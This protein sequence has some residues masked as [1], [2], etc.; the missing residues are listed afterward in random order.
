MHYIGHG[1][2]DSRTEGGILVL[3]NANGDSHEVTGEELGS[4]LQD[5]RSMRL[6]VL[7]A[8]EGARGSHVDPFC[9][10]AS[11]LVECGISAVVGMQFE[12]TDEAAI[13]FGGRL[14]SALAQGFPID[15]ALAQSRK[16]IFAAGHDIEFGT[17]VLFLRAAD[18][19]LFDPEPPAHPPV[20]PP[21]VPEPQVPVETLTPGT[22][23]AQATGD[24]AEVEASKPDRDALALVGAET[25]A[26]S[27]VTTDGRLSRGGS[28]GGRPRARPD[29]CRRRRH[30]G[31]RA[32]RPSEFARRRT[33]S[34]SGFA[35]VDAR[36]GGLRPCRGC[37][38]LARLGVGV[39]SRAGRFGRGRTGSA[40]AGPVARDTGSSPAGLRSRGR[41][42]SR[43]GLGRGR[44]AREASSPYRGVGVSTGSPRTLGPRPVASLRAASRR[45]G[46]CP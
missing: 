45:C 3:E 27:D 44:Y 46:G 10:V 14:Y 11:S 33:I 18:A 29:R 32:S 26:D 36:A 31:C 1:A 9:G 39:A 8:C 22:V 28:V 12:V 38:G 4:L 23:V 16:A 5:E 6:V 42:L 37:R 2:Y 43:R 19:R 24:A 30:V 40:R 7:N 34:P 35:T 15:A 41:C 20:G 17:P 25:A 21:V 13:T